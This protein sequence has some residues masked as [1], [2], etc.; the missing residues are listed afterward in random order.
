M[1]FP[2]GRL[3]YLIGASGA[4]KDSLLR[5]ARTALGGEGYVFAHR[6]ITRPPELEGENHIH[7][8]PEEFEARHRAGCFA[9]D[10]HSHGL[11]YGIGR[12]LD[13]WLQTGL[14]VVV[15]GS[16]AY[17]PT[18]CARY[19]QLV[20]VLVTVS[21]ERLRERLLARGRE[22]AA[23]IEA[24]LERASAASRDGWPGLRRVGNDGSLEEGARSL[25]EL[26]R[27]EAPSGAAAE[28][29]H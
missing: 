14:H 25:I 6:Y 24:R 28:S 10:W 23:E 3:F 19:A 12:E 27:Q 11:R 21:A 26:L 4:G 18:A 20:P 22:S 15:N 9:L 2:H 1:P 8:T 13:L 5:A 17:L 16:R 7:L 29:S